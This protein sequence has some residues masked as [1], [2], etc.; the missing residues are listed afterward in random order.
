MQKSLYT[1]PGQAWLEMVCL[2]WYFLYSLQSES[3]ALQLTGYIKFTKPT[4]LTFRSAKR[5][6]FL[7]KGMSECWL[8]ASFMVWV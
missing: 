1:K 7:L 4:R 5:Y 6:F 2:M 8:Q 3:P